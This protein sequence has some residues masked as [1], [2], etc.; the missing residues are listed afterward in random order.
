MPVLPPSQCSLNSA[1]Q[2]V[3]RNEE[4]DT[5]GHEERV[6]AQA[7][8]LSEL[9]MD[10]VTPAAECLDVTD[11]C[12]THLSFSVE[13]ASGRATEPL[14]AAMESTRFEP[15]DQVAAACRPPL[16]PLSSPCLSKSKVPQSCPH[17]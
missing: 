7:A 6:D 2:R 9:I 4:E 11:Y 14:V 5:L 13:S 17:R 10:N 1:M 3:L 16:S 12:V 15:E 8:A